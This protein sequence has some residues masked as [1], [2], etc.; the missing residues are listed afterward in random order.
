MR[1]GCAGKGEKKISSEPDLFFCHSFSLDVG[2]GG[3]DAWAEGFKGEQ[4]KNR[5]NFNIL[6]RPVE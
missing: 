4:E 2:G 3:R 1:D 5:E 6:R